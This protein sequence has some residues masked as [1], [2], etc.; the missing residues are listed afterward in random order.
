VNATTEDYERARMVAEDLAWLRDEWTPKVDAASVR[1]VSPLLRSLLIDGQYVRAWRAIGL[2][3]EPYISATDLAA[4]VG[5]MD[6]T[7][8]RGTPTRWDR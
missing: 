3:G 7:L 2:P 6:R 4:A 1:R 5:K 8:I